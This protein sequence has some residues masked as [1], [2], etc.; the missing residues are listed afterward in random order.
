MV[1]GLNK[2]VNE[3][4]IIHSLRATYM[5]RCLM[6]VSEVTYY[7]IGRNYLCPSSYARSIY[8]DWFFFFIDAPKNRFLKFKTEGVKNIFFATKCVGMIQD[9]YI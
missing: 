7:G 3:I 9:F 8:I 4:A 5:T 1:Y 6:H 2:F